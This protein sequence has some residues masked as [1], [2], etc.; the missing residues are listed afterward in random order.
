MHRHEFPCFLA[1]LSKFFSRQLHIP[2]SSSMIG[3]I[4]SD[5]FVSYHDTHWGVSYCSAEKLS[6]YSTAPADWAINYIVIGADVTG[7]QAAYKILTVM[8]IIFF[9][10]NQ[11]ERLANVC[12]QSLIICK[13]ICILRLVSFRKANYVFSLFSR[14]TTFHSIQRNS[15]DLNNSIEFLWL[16]YNVTETFCYQINK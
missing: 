8:N 3:T 1:H 7:T 13:L 11:V 2:Q 9:S 6:V 5:C 14:C 15:V 10:I 4:P 12:R 16:I